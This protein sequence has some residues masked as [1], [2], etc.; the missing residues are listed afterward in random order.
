MLACHLDWH[1]RRSL[2]VLKQTWIFLASM[3]PRNW[4]DFDHTHRGPWGEV[5]FTQI[6]HTIELGLTHLTL[7]LHKVAP[8]L[9]G[10]GGNDWLYRNMFMKFSRLADTIRMDGSPDNVIISILLYRAPFSSIIF[11]T[12]S[13]IQP[14]LSPTFVNLCLSLFFVYL[15]LS[16]C[17]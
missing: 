9:I 10:I 7:S 14:W 5:P 6:S 2:M 1:W 3:Q 15:F 11:S 8:S 13:S 4:P 12:F 17:K 16:F